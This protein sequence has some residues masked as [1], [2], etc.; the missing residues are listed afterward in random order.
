MFT[1]EMIIAMV[2][3]GL[4]AVSMIIAVVAIC[5]MASLNK[6]YKSFMTGRNGQSL[7][8]SIMDRLKEIEEL[9][10]DSEK[11]KEDIQVL[12]SKSEKAICKF[13]ISKYDAFN[14]SGGKLSFAMVMLDESN[15]GFSMNSMHGQE[16]SYVY[17]KEIING[18]SFIELGEEEKKALKDAL[19]IE[20][21]L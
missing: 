20:T 13:G 12:Y 4:A 7:E 18:Q 17:V 9:K 1:T 8:N 2:S 15:N 16:G 6:K 10:A 3:C 5:K 14:E 21:Q 19:G 11:S